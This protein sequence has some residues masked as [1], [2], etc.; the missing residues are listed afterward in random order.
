LCWKKS[1]E[2]EN[3]NIRYKSSN[4]KPDYTIWIT[5]PYKEGRNTLNEEMLRY[6]RMSSKPLF[7]MS[8]VFLRQELLG[9]A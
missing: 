4:F 8:C 6:Q 5:I 7:E 3:L 2:R 1:K 9:S